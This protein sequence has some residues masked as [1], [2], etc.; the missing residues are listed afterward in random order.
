M[1]VVLDHY[2]SPVTM[3]SPLILGSRCCVIYISS[4]DLTQRA[5]AYKVRKEE[6]IFSTR[7]NIDYKKEI[8][9]FT[10]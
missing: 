8:K 3:A 2:L 9:I 4:Q 10:S 6:D 7:I 1:G 5:I